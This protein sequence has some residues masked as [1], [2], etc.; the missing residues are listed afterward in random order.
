MLVHTP[1]PLK[2]GDEIRII[3]TARSVE[4]DFIRAAM[5]EI[6]SRGF[7]ASTGRNLLKRANQFAGTDEERLR[8]LN[9]ALNDR[10]VRAILC[11][12]GGYGTARL[13]KGLDTFAVRRDPKWVAGYS[14][15]TAL[16]HHLFS[17]TGLQSLHSSM[18]VNFSSNSAEAK[19]SLF[20]LLKG[21]TTTY[22]APPHSLNRAG[23][24]TGMLIGG[25]LS[26][27]Y[28]LLGSAAQLQ[29]EG[30]I[31]F[32]EDLDEY[33][34]HIDRMVL[35][36]DR[37]GL[38]EKL[39]GLIIGGMTDMNDNTVPF[40]LTAEEII[41][42]RVSGFKFPVCFGFPSGHIDDNRA[43]IHGKKIRLTVNHDQPSFIV[44][45]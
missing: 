34:Y 6:A 2:E 21:E 37:A 45:A 10:S 14:D 31:L 26:V 19:D 3:S 44:Y 7:R 38:L 36:L 27:I 29:T 40:G 4:D 35:A 9:D 16:H 18:P 15:I 23:E 24:A 17:E 5:S 8:D 11:A 28:S 33:L 1:P 39:S 20:E 41:A 25:N 22:E 43:W 32:L 13:L 12:R 30:C 42:D